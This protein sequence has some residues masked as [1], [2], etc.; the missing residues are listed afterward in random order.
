MLQ[1]VFMSMLEPSTGS[2]NG[3][4]MF[5]APFSEDLWHPCGSLYSLSGDVELL[6]AVALP[7]EA[8]AEPFK[9]AVAEADVDTVPVELETRTGLSGPFPVVVAVVADPD[10]EPEAD[11]DP[12][13]IELAGG[14][15]GAMTVV[16]PGGT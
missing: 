6:V 3:F 13:A 16:V 4:L 5:A 12:E 1:L 7:A 9:D 15:V 8:V 11:P 14:A 10:T 2:Q